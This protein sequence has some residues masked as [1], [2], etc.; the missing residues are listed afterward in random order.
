VDVLPMEDLTAAEYK[1]L[2]IVVKR[3]GDGAY[4]FSL[5][6]VPYAERFGE[7]GELS[8]NVWALCDGKRTLLECIRI[9]DG[10]MDDY[11]EGGA[12]CPIRRS[13]RKE[14]L[15]AIDFVKFAE[16]YGYCKILP[17]APEMSAKEFEKA[18]LALGVT[19][20][21]KL[22]VHS[23]FSSMGEVTGGAEAIC[24]VFQR[25][26]G[27]D[28]LLL[29]PTFTFQLYSKGKFFGKPYDVLNTPSR[30]GILG[31]T[32]RHLPG[33]YRSYDPCHP[34][35]AWGREA[36]SFVE[37]HHLVT[38]I[39]PKS[40][41]GLLEQHD[42]WCMTISAAASV[43]FMHVVEYSYG[44]RCTG[45]RTEEYDAILPDG[46]KVKLRTWS[47]REDTC[48]RCPEHRT[49]EIYALL[50]KRHALRET[51]LGNAHITLF[52]LADYRKAYE[53][54]LK[55]CCNKDSRAY[56]RTVATSV[57]SDWD[58]KRQCIKK[59]TTAYTGEFL[60]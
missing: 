16:K 38:T 6:K 11:E 33:V 59:N 26:I 55:E 57:P 27:K 23:T 5:A 52:R 34:W 47:W 48:E 56:P 22:A 36:I 20:G 3:L 46:Q 9:D 44:A 53:T 39:S 45:M 17:A 60:K 1:A 19:K 31:E 8:Q 21:M 58:E 35:A 37:G 2:N 10:K 32:F 25:V 28:G 12:D 50:R 49:A 7:H 30:V 51:M 29:M 15:A 4:P 14:I 40:P 43:T 18:I 41:I 54:L 42:G 13:S 24:D